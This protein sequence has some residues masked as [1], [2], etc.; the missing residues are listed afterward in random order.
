M[1][2]G[3]RG[4]PPVEA[5]REGGKSGEGGRLREGLEGGNDTGRK[6]E[7]GRHYTKLT[8]KITSSTKQH[9]QVRILRYIQ[10]MIITKYYKT[11]RKVT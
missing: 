10:Q 4:G 5:R 1:R 3:V 7:R 6:K 9:Y 11:K 8:T 2:E